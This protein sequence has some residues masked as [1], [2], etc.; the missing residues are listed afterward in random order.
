[1]KK[2]IQPTFYTDATVTCSS[3]GKVFKTGGTVKEL[4][5][6][7]CSNCHSFYTGKA[8]LI[9]TSGRVDKFKKR[10]AAKIEDYQKTKAQKKEKR[11]DSKIKK[12]NAVEDES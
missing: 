7:V 10:S 3:C 11:R 8:N 12:A 2:D 1:M 5:T 9:D 6:D 4:T